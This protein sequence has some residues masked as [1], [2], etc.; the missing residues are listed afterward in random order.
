MYKIKEHE[1]ISI[2]KNNHLLINLVNGC[3]DILD[4]KTYMDFKNDCFSELDIDI[5]R[6][7]IEREY[8]FKSKYDYENWINTK[9]LEIEHSEKKQAPNFI[10]VTNYDCNLNC[11]YCYQDSYEK[12]KAIKKGKNSTKDF[13]DFIEI[14]ILRLEE[15]Y[16]IKYQSE[17]ILITITGGEP[18][19]V[20]NYNKIEDI[21]KYAKNYNYSVSIVTNGTTLEYYKNIFEAYPIE[22]MQITLD[23]NKKIHDKIRVGKDNKGTFD[24]IINNIIKIRE[25]ISNLT[26][27][28]NVNANNIYSIKDLVALISELPDVTFY[29]YLMQHEGC[30]D[31][32]N[33]INEVS[34]LKYLE[35]L[36]NKSELKNF[37]IEYHGR[38]IVESVLNN[39]SFYPKASVCSA[40]N[41]QYIYD[42]NGSIFKCWW[43]MGNEDYSLGLFEN[44]KLI[45]SHKKLKTYQ[46]RNILNINK[47]KNCKY[48]FICGGGCSGRLTKRQLKNKDVICPD[49]KSIFDYIFKNK[50]EV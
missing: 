13:F 22:N 34:G 9:L 32:E 7:M 18:L 1:L 45:I 3:A 6:K 46:D 35:K 50:I 40:M 29:T 26:V 21:V 20:K 48:K 30:F 49:Y 5:R 42:S 38:E 23:G 14:M 37:I 10:F 41:N 11:Y 17:D 28:I 31:N 39:E 25:Y 44:K 8:L 27:R 33:I 24:K 12:S 16:N 4:F 2:D 15:K 43:G 19:L 36:K 47:C